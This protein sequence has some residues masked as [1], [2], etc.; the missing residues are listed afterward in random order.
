M[1]DKIK[2]CGQCRKNLIGLKNG[3]LE[4]LEELEKEHTNRMFLVKCNNCGSNKKYST[5]VFNKRNHCGY[6]TERELL[7]IQPLKLPIVKGVYT[8]LKEN[9]YWR[10]HNNEIV[11]KVEAQCNKC[12]HRLELTYNNISTKNKGCIKCAA[13]IAGKEKRDS[14][15]NWEIYNEL[16]S[17]YNNMKARCYNPDS[18]DYRNYGARG[19]T[20]CSEWLE[21]KVGYSN[22]VEW[23]V[24]N[25]YEKNLEIDRRDNE[26]GY[27]IENCR[28]VSR[29]INC[30]NTRQT[31]LTEEIVR[32]IRYGEY[33]NFNN[34]ELSQI[35]EVTPST[36]EAVKNKKTWKEI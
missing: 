1:S 2:S 19:I 3:H 29:E 27:S 30:R 13:K 31:K 24:K 6:L 16:R 22:F 20:I 25:G 15:P 10:N 12:G 33:K 35:L 14:N 26:K 28:W 34:L 4:I 21:P 17:R 7:E 32:S 8:L 11:R 18:K 5:A 23:S 9:L 36:I